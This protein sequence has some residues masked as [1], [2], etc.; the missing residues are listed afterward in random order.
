[1]HNSIRRLHVIFCYRISLLSK[2]QSVSYETEPV[3]SLNL[4]VILKQNKQK[5]NLE[6]LKS[7]MHNEHQHMLGYFTQINILRNPQSS[8]SSWAKIY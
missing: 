6:Y 8:T 2:H 7:L 3:R 1:M 5:S 4:K